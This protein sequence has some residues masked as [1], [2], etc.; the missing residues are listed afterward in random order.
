MPIGAV[1]RGLIAFAEVI[2]KTRLPIVL[3]QLQLPAISC[4]D[5]LFFACVVLSSFDEMLKAMIVPSLGSW[6]Q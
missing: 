2:G 4:P 3:E 5:H 6:E 1:E